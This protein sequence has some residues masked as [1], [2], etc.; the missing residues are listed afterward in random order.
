MGAITIL[1]AD[2]STLSNNAFVAGQRYLLTN[3]GTN[4]FLYSPGTAGGGLSGLTDDFILKANGTTA[5]EISTIKDDGAGNISYGTVSG[6]RHEFV[7]T[8]ATAVR[9]ITFPNESGTL[10]FQKIKAS[11]DADAITQDGTNCTD[12]ITGQINSG[13]RTRWFVCA[14]S[15]SS[16]FEGKITNLPYAITT[17]AFTLKLNHATT[18]S[19]TFAGD[20]SAQCRASGTTVNSTWGTAVAADVAIT[21]ANQPVQ[22]TASGVVPNGTCSAGATLFWRYV[23]DATN[24]SANAANARIMGVYL[25]AE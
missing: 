25:A 17:A 3:N 6:N 19:I 11:W 21:T 20:F 14:D 7:F 4:F 23:V 8:A 15:N 18:E 16:I 2:G 22:A 12:P 5:A 1:A 9:T 10:A 13:P 24:F